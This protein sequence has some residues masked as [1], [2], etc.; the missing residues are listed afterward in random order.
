MNDQGQEFIERLNEKKIEF[1]KR[2]LNYWMWRST[3]KD[4]FVND[5]PAGFSMQLR[6]RC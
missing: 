4:L 3:E 5:I 1:T 2:I 6:D